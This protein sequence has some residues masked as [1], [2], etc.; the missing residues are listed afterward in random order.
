MGTQKTLA[1]CGLIGYVPEMHPLKQY[2]E[3]RQLTQRQLAEL[4]DV[5]RNALARWEAGMRKID[6]ARLPKIAEVTG[7]PA[8]QLRPDLAELM[9]DAE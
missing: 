3:D 5:K 1:R 2:R 7:I 8:T 6:P 9:G 4:L